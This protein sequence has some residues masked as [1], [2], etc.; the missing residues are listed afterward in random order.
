MSGT[1]FNALSLG[2]LGISMIPLTESF[3]P[4]PQPKISTLRVAA[5]LNQPGDDDASLGGSQPGVALFDGNGNRIGFQSGKGHG[6]IEDGNYKDIEI[7][8]IDDQNTIAPEYM[9]VVAGG[10][11]AICIAYLA[12]TP[13]SS[14]YWAFYGD[15]AKSCGASWYHSNL[16]VQLDGR[17]YKPSCFWIGGPRQDT[18][19]PTNGF[20][21]GIGLHLIDF[22]STEARQT[23]YTKHPETLCKSK[24]RMHMYDM[25]SEMTCLPIFNPTLDYVLGKGDKDFSKLHTQGKAMCAPSANDIDPFPT[26]EQRRKLQKWTSGRFQEATYGTKK[27]SLEEPLHNCTHPDDLIESSHPDHSATELCQD[28]T[29]AGPD[30]VSHSEGR[31]CDMCTRT[32]WPLC[33]DKVKE[34]CFDVELKQLR[35]GSLDAQDA[36]NGT[37]HARIGARSEGGSAKVYKN[38]AKWD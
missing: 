33:G 16:A 15:V 1:V 37:S 6:N 7:T 27:R 34:G 32:L 11:N 10:D 24:P 25:L 38:T 30:F 18:G 13:P 23:Q 17:T 2:L 9:S 4:S 14:E 20:P 3:F 22:D 12:L 29:A 19:R 21:E 5:G 35:E 36:V 31:M 26:G 28:P 8:P